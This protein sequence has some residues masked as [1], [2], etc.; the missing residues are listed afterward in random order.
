MSGIPDKKRSGS[1]QNANQH[2]GI[3]KRCSECERLKPLDN[4]HKDTRKTLGVYSACKE[5][6]NG[7]RALKK[8]KDKVARIALIPVT[9]SGDNVN[10]TEKMCSKCGEMKSYDNF[11][12]RHKNKSRLWNMCKKC[13]C[14]K[15]KAKRARGEGGGKNVEKIRANT[16]KWRNLHLDQCRK[17]ARENAKKRRSNPKV[18]LASNVSCAIRASICGDKLGHWEDLVGYTAEQ[19]KAHLEKRFK[20]G[21]NWENYGRK[22]S[23]KRWEVDHK[24][25]IDAFNFQRPEDVD[26]KKCWALKNL[27]PMWGFDNRSKNAKL[28]K[29]FQPSLT[30]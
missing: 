4:F 16:R 22:G 6:H 13:Y 14:A 11:Y 26:F 21:M 3:E 28:E 24:I 23:E 2:I 25:P 27:Q 15:L 20:P 7:L 19:L 9:E 30:I 12:R 5:C 29:H 10:G 8:A 1:V 17:S 18:K